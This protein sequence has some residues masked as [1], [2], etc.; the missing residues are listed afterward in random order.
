MVDF[1]RVAQSV[2]NPFTCM[3]NCYFFCSH[4]SQRYSRAYIDF[5]NPE[6]V[7]EFAEYFDG[8]IFVNEKGTVTESI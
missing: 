8:H 5:T 2:G 1:S 7:V 4:K 3:A 6:D